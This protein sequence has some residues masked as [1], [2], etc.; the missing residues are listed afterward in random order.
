MRR[1]VK[2]SAHLFRSPILSAI[3]TAGVNGDFKLDFSGI[4][5]AKAGT[6]WI[7]HCLGQHP[8]VCMAMG[9]E[10][11]FFLRK[12][13]AS[14]LP[15]RRYHYGRSHYDEGLEWYKQKFTHH[16]AGQLN[17]EFSNGYLADPESA[18]LLHAHNP[19]MKLLCCFRNPVDAGY[20]GYFELSR[21]QPLPETAEETL[22]RYPQLLE[23]YR[24]HHNLQPFLKLFPRERI[25]FMVFDDI[26]TDP[27]GFYRRICD[28]LGIDASF[29]PPSLNERVNPRTVLRSRRLRNLRGAVG[30]FLASGP[31]GRKVRAGLVRLGVVPVAVKLLKLNEKPGTVPPLAPETRRR[32]VDFFR[33]DNESLGQ[34]IG[35]DLSHWNA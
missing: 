20:A 27:A 23:Y 32:L 11:N 9:K 28:F 1:R 13:I 7:A 24:Y 26:R 8:A 18:G 10:A 22:A 5:V 35:R 19:D 3:G 2:V 14:I 29:V 16:R 31:T 12:H 17:G 25:L 6:T 30:G 4:G 33:K 34:L 21:V 15:V